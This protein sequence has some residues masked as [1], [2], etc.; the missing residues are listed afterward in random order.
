VETEA[1]PA[2]KSEAVAEKPAAKDKPETE[3]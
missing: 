3:A 1:A 2:T